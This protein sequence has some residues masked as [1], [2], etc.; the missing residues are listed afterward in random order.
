MHLIIDLRWSET[1]N[2]LKCFFQNVPVTVPHVNGTPALALSFVLR[3]NVILDMDLMQKISVK[4]T[5]N[6]MLDNS[7]IIWEHSFICMLCEHP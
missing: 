7:H 3:D 6:C 2:N 1:I 4:V 5:F